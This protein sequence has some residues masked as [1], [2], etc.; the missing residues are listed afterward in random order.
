[1]KVLALYVQRTLPIVRRVIAPFSVLTNRGHAFYAQQVAS[2]T[3]GIALAYDAVVLSNWI[4]DDQEIALLHEMRGER[5]C[6]YDLSDPALL[7]VEQ[8]RT[9]LEACQLVTVP[10]TYL[11]REVRPYNTRVAVLPST[12]D[13]TYFMIGRNMARPSSSQPVVGCFGP[14]DWHLVK[15]ALGVLREKHPHVTILGDTSAYQALGKD[16][17]YPVDVNVDTLPGLLYSCTFGL[18]PM[19]GDKGQDTIWGLEYGTLYKPVIVA[20]NSPYARV[21]RSGSCLTVARPQETSEWVTVMERLLDDAVVRANLGKWAFTL[22]N[23][24]RATKVADVYL[25]CYQKMLPHLLVA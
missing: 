21:F 16:L 11:E 15:D 25:R 9:T 6:I 1:M 24:Q 22:A 17:V 13:L 19:D 4:L 3:P 18:C 2:F 7:Q 14:H 12:Y 23:A 20:N 5:S 10:N 8:V